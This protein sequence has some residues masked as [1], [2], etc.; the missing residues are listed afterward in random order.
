M[1]LLKMLIHNQ[2]NT[3]YLNRKKLPDYLKNRV[4]EIIIT[5]NI[6][7]NIQIFNSYFID[8]IKN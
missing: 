4:F 3:P 8:K 5:K 7:N 1:C 6:P 2:L